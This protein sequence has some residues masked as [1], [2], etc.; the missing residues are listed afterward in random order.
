[1]I[2]RTHTAE[3][4]IQVAITLRTVSQQATAWGD[5]RGHGE[6]MIV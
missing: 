6:A 2:R 4:A 1:M 5:R 3:V